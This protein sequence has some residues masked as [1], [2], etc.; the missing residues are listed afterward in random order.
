MTPVEVPHVSPT[1]PAPR[2]PQELQRPDQ[3]MT[4][5]L[6]EKDLTSALRKLIAGPFLGHVGKYSLFRYREIIS[7][8]KQE[9]GRGPSSLPTVGVEFP[10]YPK[11]AV[12]WVPVVDRSCCFPFCFMRTSGHA[13]NS[14]PPVGGLRR[15]FPETTFPRR[16]RRWAGLPRPKGRGGARR[17]ER[18]QSL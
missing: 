16:L 9:S 4:Q 15:C 5:K 12:F 8:L 11:L 10:S 7:W 3:S 6:E 14:R 18:T 13:L 1:P 2:I 17:S